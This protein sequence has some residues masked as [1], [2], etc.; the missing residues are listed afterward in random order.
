M[1]QARKLSEGEIS[2]SLIDV[3]RGADSP[4]LGSLFGGQDDDAHEIACLVDR[5]EAVAQYVLGVKSVYLFEIMGQM[6]FWRI[7]AEN[8]SNSSPDSFATVHKGVLKILNGMEL[9]LREREF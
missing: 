2:Y 8:T 7:V 1:S 3:S 6:T 4:L 5:S 9:S